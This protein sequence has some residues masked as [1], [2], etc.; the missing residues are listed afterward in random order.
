MSKILPNLP[1]F[2]AFD[3]KPIVFNTV[4]EWKIPQLSPKF[5]S[6][7]KDN[8]ADESLH[9][10]QRL[11]RKIESFDLYFN[12]PT[13]VMERQA[14]FYREVILHSRS[15]IQLH[16]NSQSDKTKELCNSLDLAIIK[17]HYRIQEENGGL[18][19]LKLDEIDE[20]IV[21]QLQLAVENHKAED[22]KYDY[23][24]EVNSIAQIKE[25]CHYPEIAKFLLD[26][27][28]KKQSSEYFQRAMRDNFPIEALNQYHYESKLLAD[29][30]IAC[31]IGAIAKKLLSVDLVAKKNGSL[32]KK[33]HLLME[34]K[35]VNLLNKK[36]KVRFSN[37]LVWK[38]SR[39]YKDFREKN[40][41]PGDLEIM[42][43]GVVPFNGHEISHRIIH[44]NKFLHRFKLTRVFFKRKREYASLDTLKP[45]WFEKTRVLDIRTKEYI[46]A[47]Y[48]VKVEPGQ[49]VAVLE[50]TRR[51][52]LDVDKAHGY[53][54]FY[55]PLGNNRYRVYSFGAFP[56]KF[57]QNNRELADF[58][59]DTVKGTIA[60]DPNYFYSQS[61]KASWPLVVNEEVALALLAELGSLKKRGIIFQ[62]GWENC[63]FLIRN[64]F[65]KVLSEM[66][67]R[68]EVPKFFE[69]KFVNVEPKGALH[70]VKNLFKNASKRSLPVLKIA[71][72][73]LFRA[74]RSITVKENGKKVKK[75]LWNSPFFKGPESK[76]NAPSAMHYRIKKDRIAKIDDPQ[77]KE[78][79]ANCVLNY[80]HTRNP[81]VAA[82]AP[83]A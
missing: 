8:E 82:A 41:N 39:I 74:N 25:I 46:E 40:D 10:V 83:A 70:I 58:V 49:W 14:Q 6:Q 21:Q 15:I 48:N 69:K 68:I 73:L 77:H 20:D 50:A 81:L 1:Q 13:E 2:S 78:K 35:K 52:E 42:M 32:S 29:N 53:S 44:K 37:G 72:A 54:V 64:V 5:V 51:N 24:Q 22:E 7:I 12:A 71:L 17:L 63:A 36:Q 43:D 76:I 30:F 34:D 33:L 62:L 38:L 60:F 4:G 66:Q 57:P 27:N 67:V 16:Q 19:T 23:T 31:R 18:R 59:G 56:L 26:P 45:R 75:S 80:G 11:L 65:I 9:K 47:R 28:H 55:Q 79:F 61:Q 3:N